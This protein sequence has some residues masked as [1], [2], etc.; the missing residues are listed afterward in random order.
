MADHPSRIHRYRILSEIGRGAMGRVYLAVDPNIDRKIALKV[1]APQAICEPIEA[2]ELHERF[3]LEARAAGRLNHPGIVTVYDAD[4]DPVSGDS[5]L[6]MEWVKGRSLHAM[7]QSDEP[8]PL[9][10]TLALGSQVARALDY[11][12]RHDVVHR[13]V[14]PSNLLVSSDGVV[15]VV[16]FGIA[17]LMTAALTV[18]GS[19]FGTPFYMSPEQVKGEAV[20]GRTDLFALGA[21]LY[22]CV[23][24]RRAFGGDSLSNV[25]YKILSVQPRPPEMYRPEV[26]PSLRR[27]LDRLLAKRPEDRYASGDEVAAALAAVN[28]KAD[29]AD[30][31]PVASHSA[32]D[33]RGDSATPATNVATLA[34]AP[35]PPP[36]DSSGVSSPGPSDAPPRASATPSEDPSSASADPPPSES[37]PPAAEP[38]RPPRVSAGLKRFDVALL[39]ALAG[40]S[41]ILMAEASVVDNLLRSGEG[42]FQSLSEGLGAIAW[43]RQDAVPSALLEIFFRHP[44]SLGFVTVWIDGQRTMTEKLDVADAGRPPPELRRLIAVP[45]GRRSVEVHVSGVSSEVE[46]RKMIYADFAEGE[47]KQLRVELKP[48]SKELEMVLTK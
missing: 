6:A 26:S 36:P 44:L 42:M 8:L 21:V 20:D 37:G 29:V 34:S 13:D 16:D 47:K 4:A 27:V 19:V 10:L 28:E 41:L 31:R 5:Y 30:D 25:N 40:L 17:K 38:W 32:G 43:W 35:Q 45:A 1:L 24:G 11:A 12:H 3:L 46:A 22:E 18:P 14:K 9:A 2:A 48:G 15:K 23:T 7:L 39:M 33:A